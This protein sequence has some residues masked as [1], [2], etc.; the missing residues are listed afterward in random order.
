MQYVNRMGALVLLACPAMLAAQ[1]PDSTPPA[2]AP[3]MTVSG[4]V[5]TSF[6][7]SS[8]P[9]GK[10]IVG[11]LYE[12]RQNEPMLNVINVTLERVAA[13]SKLDAGFRIEGW[14]GQNARFVKSAGLDLGQNAD[15]WQAYASVNFPLSGEG[16]Y[17]QIKAGKMATLMG[18]EVGEDVLNQNLD[19]SWQDIYLEPFTETG[20]ELDGKFG[21]H[22]DVELRVSNGWDQV[23]DVNSGKTFMARLGLTPDD[24]TLIA[25]VGYLG[26]EQANNTSNQR[27]GAD[28]LLTR[29][30]TSSS[31][32]SA[33]LDVGQEDGAAAAGGQAR[34][35]AAGAWLSYDVS[36][37]ATLALR[38]DFMDDHDG[39]RT[40]GVLGFPANTGQRIGS[41]TATLNLKKWKHVL[42]RPE[43]RYDRSDLEVFNGHFSQ[44]TFGLGLSLLF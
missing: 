9:S 2:A 22:F 17:L 33:Q 39:A 38:G 25:L 3:F 15:I 19:V 36:S 11:R 26:P 8:N 4:S 35:Y 27:I 32:L 18:I 12:R 5:T 44:M 40:S 16:R 10:D 30:V 31:T 7:T 43:V 28:V 20:M 6:T 29:K 24:K 1:K 21:P 13:T 41:G 34:W 37:W 14:L 23:K 42:V